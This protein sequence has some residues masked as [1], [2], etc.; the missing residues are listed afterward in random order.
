MFDDVW[1]F[2]ST[3]II[4]SFWYILIPCLYFDSKALQLHLHCQAVSAIAPV[5][6]GHHSAVRPPR[7]EGEIRGGDVD[8]VVE[9]ILTESDGIWPDLISSLFWDRGA[10]ES[11]Y[12]FVIVSEETS[13]AI[14]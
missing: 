11:L 13:F 4:W 1:R 2:D 8:H 10:I 6:P 7:S 12:V 9:L 3:W 5:A 14:K